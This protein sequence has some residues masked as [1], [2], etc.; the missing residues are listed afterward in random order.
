MSHPT[1]ITYDEGVPDG[2]TATVTLFNSAT[3]FPPG[4][5]FHLLGQQWFQYSLRTASNGGAAT[6]TVTGSFSLDKGTTWRPFYTSSTT[7]ADDDDAAA[8]GDVFADEVYVGMYK[9]VRFQYTNAVEQLTVFEANLALNCH[10][11]TSKVTRGHV[12]HD[13]DSAAADIAVND[14][15]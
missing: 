8:T 2:A 13:N 12:L 1:I 11:A 15:P 7:D 9:D 6:G 3:A 10:K 4:G 14:A 5:C